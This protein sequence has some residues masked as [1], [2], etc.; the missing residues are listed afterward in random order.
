[1]VKIKDYYAILG[2]RHFTASQAEIRAAYLAQVKFFHP[3]ANNVTPE[4]A[5]KKMQE[6]NKIYATLSSPEKKATYDELLSQQIMQPPKAAQVPPSSPPRANTP[7]STNSPNHSQ[8]QSTARKKLLH[9]FLIVAG[10]ALCLFLSFLLIKEYQKL[11]PPNS[12]H[13]QVSQSGT[14]DTPKMELT[15]DYD[16]ALD[17]QPT[18]PQSTA[19][20]PAELKPK[21][22]SNG[23]LVLFPTGNRV[24]PLQV[25][26]TA[27]V[28]GYYIVMTSDTLVAENAAPTKNT[29]SFYVVG[30]QSV[31]IDVPVG[32][33]EIWYATGAIWYGKEE[34]FGSSTQYYKCEGTFD[35]FLDLETRTYMGWE[36]S[37]YPSINGNMQTDS[38]N[39]GDFPV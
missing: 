5:T 9:A 17:Q 35:F 24:A 36:L 29:L 14:L 6:L 15:A 11:V 25:N 2:I 19:D 18:P 33:Y 30:G 12:L 4:I 13:P 16:A 20:L 32:V 39:A 38:V 22:I 23:E 1:M 34:K 26:T 28:N 10:M 27:D 7:P 3:D 37:L 31:K 8:K 21:S